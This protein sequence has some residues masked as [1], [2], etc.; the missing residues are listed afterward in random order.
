MSLILAS[1]SPRRQQLLREA[2]FTFEVLVRPAEEI[3]P[4]G[5]SPVEAAIAIAA[6]KAAVYA[7][8]LASHTILTADTVV[9]VDARIL[10]KPAD[11][12]EATAMLKML[13]GRTHSVVTGVTLANAH[14]VHSFACETKVTFR[15]LTDA[16]I[17]HYVER[18]RPY[19]KA[20]AY[21]IQEW[22]GMVGITGIDGD[23]YNVMGLPIA[24]LYEAFTRLYPHGD[25]RG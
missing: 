7:D 17:A 18:Y 20:G 13:S 14:A 16:E 8:L 12:A 19:D 10:G 2:G 5:A 6:A 1:Q 21:G 24:A 11:A 3:V 25:Y 15:I 22:I 23:Y 9:A 4:P